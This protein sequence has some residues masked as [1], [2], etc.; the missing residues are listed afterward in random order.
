MN[1]QYDQNEE[2][3]SDQVQETCMVTE[4]QP[5]CLSEPISIKTV[6]YVENLDTSKQFYTTVLDQSPILDA[7][8]LVEFQ[9][10]R[11]FKLGL[12]PLKGIVHTLNLAVRHRPDGCMPACEICLKH[13]DPEGCLVLFEAAG[14]KLIQPLKHMDWGE[15]VAYGLD[16]DGH[17][18]AFSRA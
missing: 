5:S 6:F 3:D 1:R 9:L 16:P 2:P 14:G 11:N 13:E 17:M 7:P 8:E 10:M 18:I 12:V 4:I 15:E